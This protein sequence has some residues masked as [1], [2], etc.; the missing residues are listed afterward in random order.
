LGEHFSPSHLLQA[1]LNPSS[2]ID[3]GTYLE[4]CGVGRHGRLFDL[5]PISMT[6]R[7]QGGDEIHD[8]IVATRSEICGGITQ[9]L[10]IGE[11]CCLSG[12]LLNVSVATVAPI[13]ISVYFAV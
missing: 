11:S 12:K 3:Y 8:A 13:P 2:T 10:K 5:D 9:W 7:R 4:E 1:I 6:C